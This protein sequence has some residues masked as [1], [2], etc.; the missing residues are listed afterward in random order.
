V[1]GRGGQRVEDLWAK[2]GPRAYLGCMLP[3]F[4]NMFLLYGP[5]TNPFGGLGVVSMEEMITRFVL[6]C[7]Q[8]LILDKKRSVDVTLDAYRRYNS[9]LDEAEKIMLYADKKA[10][11]YYRNEYGRSSSNC[12]FPVNKTWAWL[13]KPNLDEVIER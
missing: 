9:E 10:K 13:R 4:P 8:R 1:R 2:D 5:N 3:G 12:P 7:F 6:E 11:N